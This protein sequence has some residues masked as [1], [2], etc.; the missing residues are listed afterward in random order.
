[1]EHENTI[2]HAI[3]VIRK[4]SIGLLEKQ[5]IKG[6]WAL[7][8]Q[9]FPRNFFHRLKITA[10][11]SGGKGKPRYN[12]KRLQHKPFSPRQTTAHS[13]HLTAEAKEELCKLEE[14][15][16]YQEFLAKEAAAKATAA[17]EQKETFY[18]LS[19]L[20]RE[21]EEIDRKKLELAQRYKES[22]TV[23]TASS[24]LAVNTILTTPPITPVKRADHL[25]KLLGIAIPNTAQEETIRKEAEEED[26]LLE[27]TNSMEIV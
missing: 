9:L 18:E 14:D 12:P 4:E 22:L 11:Y 17:R 5:D 23:N 20:V 13:S 16:R 24:S 2:V 6:C 19:N 3:A 7:L 10:P 25:R 15:Q 21:Q 1:V 26:K 27:D 8:D